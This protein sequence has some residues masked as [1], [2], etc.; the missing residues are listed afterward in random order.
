LPIGITTSLMSGLPSRET[1]TQGP[2]PSPFPFFL[3]T[4]VFW[5][6]A[7][8]QTPIVDFAAVGSVGSSRRA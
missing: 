6:L 5:R 3:R 7:V 1:C 8:A 2:T 4:V